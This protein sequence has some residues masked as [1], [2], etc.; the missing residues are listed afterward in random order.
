MTEPLK[1]RVATQE[2]TAEETFRTGLD[3]V[4]LI[5]QRLA[6]SCQTVEELVASC[7]LAL[8]NDV[9]L[10]LLMDVVMQGKPRK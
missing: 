5:G 10:R 8:E 6:F 4:A 1:A 7:Q 3:A 9:H 2:A